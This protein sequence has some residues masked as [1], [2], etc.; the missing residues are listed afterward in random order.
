MLETISI[1]ILKLYVAKYNGKVIAANLVVFYGETCTYLHGASD[2]E[3]RNVMAPYLLQWQ[4]IR[5]AK[6]MGCK[7]YDFGGV[8]TGRKKNEERSKKNSWEGITRFKLGFSP[9]TKPVEFPGCYDIIVSPVRYFM[10][11]VMQKIKS[12]I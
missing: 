9:N 11:R 6:K 1:D 5:D 2:D 10:Y 4:Q 7:K 12:F 8:K 3:Y